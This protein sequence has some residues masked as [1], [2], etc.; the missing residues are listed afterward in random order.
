MSNTQQNVNFKLLPSVKT[1]LADLNLQKE[2][3]EHANTVDA[4]FDAFLRSHDADDP[5]VR[6]EIMVMRDSLKS[7]FFILDTIPKEMRNEKLNK[8]LV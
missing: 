3:K 5:E 8:F 7:L 1:W 6:G 2:P 4:W